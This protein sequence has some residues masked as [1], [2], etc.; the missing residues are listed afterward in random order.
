MK[1]DLT[2][3]LMEWRDTVTDFIDT[4]DDNA[5]NFTERDV[6]TSIRYYLEDV[7]NDIETVI[8]KHNEH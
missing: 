1:N 3:L 8:E 7:L 6:N 5:R 4:G 2:K